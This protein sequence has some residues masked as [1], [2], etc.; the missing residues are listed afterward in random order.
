M[1]NRRMILVGW[2]SSDASSNVQE[3]RDNAN[4]DDLDIGVGDFWS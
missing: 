2:F 3:D 1:L 4:L